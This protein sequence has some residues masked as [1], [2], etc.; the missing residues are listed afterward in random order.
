MALASLYSASKAAINGWSRSIAMAWGKHGITV[1]IVNPTVWTPM[2]GQYRA[3]LDEAQLKAHD[4]DMAKRVHVG[5]KLGDT[6][7]DLIPVLLFM[8]G[9]GSRFVTGQLINVDGGLL[10]GR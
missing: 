10:M 4:E 7:K 3:R 6:E 8:L 9:D 5:G 2:Y 1:N